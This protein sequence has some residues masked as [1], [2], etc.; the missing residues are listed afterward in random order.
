MMRIF[1]PSWRWAWVAGLLYFGALL[2]LSSMPE[3]N[4]P[5]LD[6]P[7]LDKVVHFL[8]YAGLGW[9]WAGANLPRWL[10]VVACLGFGAVDELSQLRSAGRDASW[11]DWLADV[12]GFAFGAWLHL[13]L[14]KRILGSA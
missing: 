11:W 2:S 6:L 8:L 13:T 12:L 7:G 9:W 14:R 1:F 5:R 4:L 10:L 3:S